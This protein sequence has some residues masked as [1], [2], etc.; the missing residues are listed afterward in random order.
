MFKTALWDQ[1]SVWLDST[2]THQQV[3]VVD[4]VEMVSGRRRTNQLA[5]FGSGCVG[6]VD[7]FRRDCDEHCDVTVTT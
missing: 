1:G 7:V 2:E 3:S 6:D 5:T 4:D